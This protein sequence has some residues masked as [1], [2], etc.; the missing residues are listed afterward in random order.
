MK[1]LP[2]V[3][4]Y[5]SIV[6]VCLVGFLRAESATLI[7]K[8]S[9]PDQLT[10][11]SLLSVYS[12]TVIFAGVI[13]WFIFYSII[14]H[15]IAVVLGKSN[16]FK[17]LVSLLGLAYLPQIISCMIVFFMIFEDVD[18]IS[19]AL[20][21]GQTIKAALSGAN[22]FWTRQ[23]DNLSVFITYLA[24]FYIIHK[25]YNFRTFEAMLIAFLPPVLFEGAKFY[26]MTG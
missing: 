11:V 3:P 10:K 22:I 23:V 7:I 24:S 18:Y 15:I 20:I 5:I 9:T 16:S 17:G 25:H 13:L 8:A 12:W 2:T 1:H 4:V 26:F 19:K 14:I 21:S 6:V